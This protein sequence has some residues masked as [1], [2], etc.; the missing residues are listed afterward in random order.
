MG[1]WS[2]L[3]TSNRADAV[4]VKARPIAEDDCLL[5]V[6]MLLANLVDARSPI[7]IELSEIVMVPTPRIRALLDYLT[8]VRSKHGCRVVIV[9]ERSRGRRLLR[10]L[11]DAD[12]IPI[13]ASIDEALKAGTG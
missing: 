7:V 6:V 13:A 10:A 8:E 9:V 4:I 3:S 5:Q 2:W 12:S 1:G 11:S